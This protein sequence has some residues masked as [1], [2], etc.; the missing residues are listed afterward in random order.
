MVNVWETCCTRVFLDMLMRIFLVVAVIVTL[1][2]G[3]NP[4][5]P[6]FAVGERD[7]RR[8]PS[9]VKRD[10]LIQSIVIDHPKWSTDQILEVL[11][12]QLR[13]AKL[14]PVW[15]KQWLSQEVSRVR[16]KLKL[17]PKKMKLLPEHT[18]FLEAEFAK[19]PKQR[20]PRIVG[21][22]RSKFG[23]IAGLETYQIRGW[24]YNALRKPNQAL[25]RKTAGSPDTSVQ[26]EPVLLDLGGDLDDILG[27]GYAVDAHGAN[28]LLD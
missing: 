4:G 15:S 1:T 27:S 18:A 26:T 8:Q 2:P 6:S 17:P 16:R 22:F 9:L 24:W 3:S 14:N 20:A 7:C 19:D 12:P 11:A 10:E 13:A 23:P 25:V 5:S 21:K 28:Y